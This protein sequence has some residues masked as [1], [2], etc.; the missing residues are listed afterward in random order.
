MLSPVA[1]PQPARVDDL[2]GIC[3]LLELCQLPAADL[4][5]ARLQHFL[6]LRAGTGLAGVAGLEVHSEYGLL[7]SVAISQAH[8]SATLGGLLVSALEARA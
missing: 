5:A 7:R 8:R 4:N 3:A 2:A 6:V 1:G